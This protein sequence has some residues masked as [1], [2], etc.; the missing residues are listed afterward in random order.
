MDCCTR[1]AKFL[2]C[3]FNFAF[4][5]VGS[6]ILTI[7][8]WI[9]ADKYHFLRITKLDSVIKTNAEAQNIL[10]EFSNP[11][12]LDHTAYILIAIGGFVFIISFL[13]YC[14]SLQESRLMLTAYG[15]FLIIIFALQI[16]GIVLCVAYRE[17]ADQEVRRTLRRSITESYTSQQYRDPVTLSWDLIMANMQCCG[18][19]NYTDFHSA[20]K[21]QAGILEEGLARK[22]PDACCVLQGEMALMKPE[23]DN[24]VSLP[25]SSNSYLYQGC[26]DKFVQLAAENLNILFGSLIGLGAVQ[27]VAIVFAFCICKSAGM[28]ERQMYYNNYK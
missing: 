2:L 16:A 21:F 8:L 26:Y 20:A 10:H 24:C 11:S 7:G 6:V 3:L 19:N 28:D 25:T 18:V 22:I 14:G 23:D 27:F 4:F 12:V 13:G 9:V 5:I 1:F 17:Q 15:L